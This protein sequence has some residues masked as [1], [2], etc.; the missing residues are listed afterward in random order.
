[1]ANT[2]ENIKD[3]KWEQVQI[4]AF[5]SWVNSTLEKKNIPPVEDLKTDF[6]DGVRL[7][8]FLETV[9]NKRIGKYDSK[10]SHQIQK[11]QNLS[12]ALQFV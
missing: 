4:K 12:I 1:M 3:K 10:P 2:E 11:I 8:N 6:Q 7:C 5:K 9:S